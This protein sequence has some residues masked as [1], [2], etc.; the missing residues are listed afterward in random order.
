MTLGGMAEEVEWRQ[1]LSAK[2]SGLEGTFRD[3]VILEAETT[4][5]RKFLVGSAALGSIEGS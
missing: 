3:T 4:A 2:P 5:Q 1:R